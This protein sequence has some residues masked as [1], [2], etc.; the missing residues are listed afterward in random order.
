MELSGISVAPKIDYWDW[1]PATETPQIDL[2]LTIHF[3]EQW[4]PLKEGRIKFGLRGG[5]LRLRLVGAEIPIESR[6]LGGSVELLLPINQEQQREE[7]AQTN[8]YTPN[9]PLTRGK[10][11]EVLSKREGVRIAPF[12]TQENFEELSEKN[13]PFQGNICHITKKV[14]EANPTWIF[15]EEIGKPVLK[16]FLHKVKLA[17]LNVTAFPCRIQATFEVSGRDICLTDAEGL[18]QSDISRNKRA[19]LEQLTIRRVLEP[20]FKPYLSRVLLLYE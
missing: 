13:H 20:K 7:I 19:V 17:T 1:L 4:E 2:Y 14:S 11:S 12:S 15:E 8:N 16:G 9:S 18:W 6:H 5:E 10:I 3:N